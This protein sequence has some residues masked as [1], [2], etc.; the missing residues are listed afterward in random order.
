VPPRDLGNFDAEC[1]HVQ[2]RVQVHN[3]P[4]S[5]VSDTTVM[6]SGR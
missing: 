5:T 6:V 2:I 3:L 4:G 1:V